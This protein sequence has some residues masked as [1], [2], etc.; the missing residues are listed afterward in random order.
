M[1]EA[2]I[3]GVDEAGRGSLAGPVVAGACILPRECAIHHY[4]RDSKELSAAQRDEA[5][6]WIRKHC[7]FG[8]GI[9]SAKYIDSHGILE[10]TQKAMQDAVSDMARTKK[11]TY[12]LIDG[13]D[14]FWFDYSHSSI[15]KGDSIE[16][17][18]SAASVV[19]KVTRDRMMI[20]YSLSLSEYGF[21]AHKGYGTK[22]HFEALKKMGTSEIHRQS[23]LTNHR[24]PRCKPLSKAKSLK[25]V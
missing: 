14:A 2:I 22:K 9:A 17:C 1:A 8:V 24:F 20:D 25:R 5:F 13:R 23:F 3:A 7:H 11:P 6:E 21:E 10:A 16:P 15:I 4:I 19:A 18:I 12:L